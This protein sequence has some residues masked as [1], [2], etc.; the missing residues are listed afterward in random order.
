MHH[1][2]NQYR[3]VCQ[4]TLLFSLSLLCFWQN[5]WN[6]KLNRMHVCTI[7]Y[8]NVQMKGVVRENLAIISWWSQKWRRGNPSLPQPLFDCGKT[9]KK[10]VF[11]QFHLFLSALTFQSIVHYAKRLD[12][13]GE[14][15][16]AICTAELLKVAAE[17]QF[18]IP[19]AA[20]CSSKPQIYRG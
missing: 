15:V 10:P 5:I 8:N 20:E 7:V 19:L 4:V 9:S 16:W 12:V 18:S 17:C 2:V 13:V 6:T 3:K 14:K 1:I 11:D